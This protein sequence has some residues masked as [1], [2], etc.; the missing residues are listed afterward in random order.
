MQYKF[1]FF[2]DNPWIS[3]L[4]NNNNGDKGWE[5]HYSFK[6]KKEKNLMQT[7]PIFGIFTFFYGLKLV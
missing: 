4:P 6:M 2:I 1:N 5:Q 3:K 7:N